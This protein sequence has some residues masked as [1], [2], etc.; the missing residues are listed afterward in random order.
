MYINIKYF[1]IWIWKGTQNVGGHK[2]LKTS[3]ICTIFNLIQIKCLLKCLYC[4][5]ILNFVIKQLS[6]GI[7]VEKTFFACN[8][9]SI[10][11]I[12]YTT[13]FP[14]KCLYPLIWIYIHDEHREYYTQTV[15]I[16]N[17]YIND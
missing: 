5:T 10:F 3:N 12:F 16:Y 6:T 9:I 2:Q 13:I 14:I 1:V 11:I 7:F 17:L 4:S 8:R 15:G